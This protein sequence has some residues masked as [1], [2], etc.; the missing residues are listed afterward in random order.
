MP[1]PELDLA[2]HHG[3]EQER[4][5]WQAIFGTK[6]GLGPKNADEGKVFLEQSLRVHEERAVHEVRQRCHAQRRELRR[7]NQKILAM[8]A[9]MTGS[10][11]NDVGELRVRLATSENNWRKERAER[12]R[13]EGEL[14]RLR[15]KVEPLFPLL[16]LQLSPDEMRALQ[17]SRTE[18]SPEPERN[19]SP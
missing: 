9:V 8:R 6:P 13:L 10:Y 16:D 17:T 7:L 5:K 18:P 14:F 1:A 15:E 12:Q 11:C 3:V 2:F 19:E 4:Q